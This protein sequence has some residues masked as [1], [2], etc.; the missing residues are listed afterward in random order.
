M[1]DNFFYNS[2]RDFW[3]DEEINQWGKDG[4]ATF[5]LEK[6]QAA[7]K[8]V[9]DKINDQAYML[10]LVTMPTVFIHS[11]DVKVFPKHLRLV[12]AVGDLGWAD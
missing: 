11:K 10:P 8:K 6:R 3:R 1:M 5:D 9:L 12:P 7:Y 4:L 2:G